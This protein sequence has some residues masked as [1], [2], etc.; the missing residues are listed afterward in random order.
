MAASCD[1]IAQIAATDSMTPE[2]VRLIKNSF[3]TMWPMR[4]DI[5]ELCYLRFFE[6]A[7]EAKALFKDDMEQQRAKLMDMIAALVGSLDQ[8]A[9]FQSIVATS[10]RQHARFG[11]RASQYTAL[12]EALM[13]SLER[14]L[15]ASLTPELLASWQALYATVQAEMQRAAAR[16]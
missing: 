6:L 13:W 9:I 2:Q 7:P 14:K 8:H 15:G 16:A 4:G 1:G 11:V 3:D 5:A 10:G 12:G